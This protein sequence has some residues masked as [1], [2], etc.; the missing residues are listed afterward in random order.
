MTITRQSRTVWLDEEHGT[1][2]LVGKGVGSYYIPLSTIDLKTLCELGLAIEDAL[3]R[4]GGS[5]KTAVAIGNAAR[6]VATPVGPA[7]PSGPP[8]TNH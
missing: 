4:A 8:P 2:L 6:Q 7:V 1:E 5:E 3:L